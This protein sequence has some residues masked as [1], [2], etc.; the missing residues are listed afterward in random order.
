MAA[1]QVGFGH[2]PRCVADGDWW[3]DW[4]AARLAEHEVAAIEG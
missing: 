2:R 1:P 4:A 3:G